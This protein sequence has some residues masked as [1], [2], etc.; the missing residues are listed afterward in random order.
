MFELSLELAPL[1]VV[2]QRTAT[3]FLF[4]CAVVAGGAIFLYWVMNVFYSA[5]SLTQGSMLA[6]SLLWNL[7]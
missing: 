1:K 5:F 2:H 6:Q 7:Y 4:L 3:S